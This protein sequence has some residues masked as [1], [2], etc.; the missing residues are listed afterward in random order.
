MTMETPATTYARMRALALLGIESEKPLGETRRAT[1]EFVED[2]EFDLSE[3]QFEAVELVHTDFSDWSRAAGRKYPGLAS[4]M[5]GCLLTEI[6][7]FAAEFF[8]H[9]PAK[10]LEI[11]RDLCSRT[12]GTPRAE[13]R[14]EMLKPGLEVVPAGR[15]ELLDELHRQLFD[16]H[17]RY[18]T[19]TTPGRVQILMEMHDDLLRNPDGWKNAGKMLTA[20]HPGLCRISK[21][22]SDLALDS[23][24]LTGTRRTIRNTL[25]KLAA[26]KTKKWSF[27]VGD[28]GGSHIRWLTVVGIVIALRVI[29]AVSSSSN[30]NSRQTEH[31]FRIYSTPQSAVPSIPGPPQN[32]P[33]FD[34]QTGTIKTDN[35]E[36]TMDELMREFL[37][38]QKKEKRS[39]KDASNESQS[40]EEAQTGRH[41]AWEFCD[42]TLQSSPFSE[43]C[44]RPLL[45][46]WPKERTA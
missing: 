7:T 37:E 26:K 2:A 18:F 3:A 23:A 4:E 25:G 14:L 12:A 40:K 29:S 21:P 5:N 27:S 39:Q 9:P 35:Y 36:K 44:D 17:V 34:P 31:Q 10:R 30:K 32:P 8:E 38:R 43:W 11:W 22:V 24:R 19:Q 45:S 33:Q 13:Q 28:S 6:E 46:I 16:W 20:S 41:G 15:G 1:L 42:S